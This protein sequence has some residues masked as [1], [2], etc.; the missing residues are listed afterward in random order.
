MTPDEQAELERLCLAVIHEKDPAKFTKL[1][2]A[3]NHF[4][5]CREQVRKASAATLCAESLDARTA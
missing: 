5:E 1:L 3:L 2:E 4:L